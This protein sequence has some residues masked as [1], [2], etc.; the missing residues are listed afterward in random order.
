MGLYDRNV[1]LTKIAVQ[2]NDL[3]FG[4][5][6]KVTRSFDVQCENIYD[7]EKPRSS[8]LLRRE[9]TKKTG[10]RSRTLLKTWRRIC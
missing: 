2:V 9:T 4:Y 8:R 6:D 5:K 7:V 10:T 1:R 3:V